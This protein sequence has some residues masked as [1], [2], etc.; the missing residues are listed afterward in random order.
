[1]TY[2]TRPTPAAQRTQ[3]AY[4]TPEA[5]RELAEQAIE[6]LYDNSDTCEIKELRTWSKALRATIARLGEYEEIADEDASLAA[7]E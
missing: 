2:K 3:R 4:M 5:F 7:A 6:D 1:M